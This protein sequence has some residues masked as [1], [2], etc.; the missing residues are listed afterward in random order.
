M[1]VP[2]RCTRPLHGVVEELGSTTLGCLVT[3]VVT[4][5]EGFVS[6]FCMGMN[7]GGGVVHDGAIVKWQTIGANKGVASMI[8]GVSHQIREDDS[9]GV[10]PPKLIVGNLQEYREKHLLDWQEVIVSGFPFKG[11]KGFS[12]LLETERD[13]AMRWCVRCPCPPLLECHIFFVD[14]GTCCIEHPQL[15][16]CLEMSL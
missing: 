16:L 7:N 9:E 13:C 2:P 14:N 3:D 12:S 8:G 1:R 4:N 11:G 15:V 5:K 6:Q 10:D